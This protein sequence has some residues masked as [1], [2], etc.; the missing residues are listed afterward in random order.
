MFIEYLLYAT[1]CSKCF[2][3]IMSDFLTILRGKNYDPYLA[4]EETEA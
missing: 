4:E 3:F 2:S 1:H